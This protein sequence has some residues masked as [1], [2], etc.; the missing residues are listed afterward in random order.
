MPHTAAAMADV[1]RRTSAPATMTIDGRQI[2][3]STIS[4]APT[5][6]APAP[7]EAGDDRDLPARRDDHQRA[8]DD[9]DDRAEDGHVEHASVEREQPAAQRAD[10]GPPPR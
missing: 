3:G 5:T 1:A 7:A 9:R 6:P 4:S 8:G 2:A 10:G